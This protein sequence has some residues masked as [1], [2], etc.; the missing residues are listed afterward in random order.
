MAKGQLEVFGV[1]VG[2]TG[3]DLWVV[4]ERLCLVDL[5]M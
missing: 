2:V 4:M 3:A 5:E 1:Q